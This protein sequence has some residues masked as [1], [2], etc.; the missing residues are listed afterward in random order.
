DNAHHYCN[1][2]GVPGL[3]YIA[4][5]SRMGTMVTVAASCDPL[6]PSSCDITQALTDFANGG[7]PADKQAIGEM[8]VTLSTLYCQGDAKDSNLC[9][10]INSVKQ[11]AGND[12]VQLAELLLAEFAAN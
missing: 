3:A 10:E 4:S 6:N 11:V 1:K 12:Y 7:S 5:L 8:A 9:V 2:T